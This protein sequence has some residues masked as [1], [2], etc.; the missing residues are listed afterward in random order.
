VSNAKTAAVTVDVRESHF[1]AWKVVESSA[2][3]EKLS[4]TETRFRLA[5]PAGGETVLTYTV[6]IES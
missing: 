4:S 5:V 3:A 2:P 6:Q 1:G